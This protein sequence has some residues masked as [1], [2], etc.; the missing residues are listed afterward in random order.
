MEFH[1]DR[2]LK[3]LRIEEKFRELCLIISQS[4]KKYVDSSLFRNQSTGRERKAR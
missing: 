1:A 3:G 4:V 2:Q